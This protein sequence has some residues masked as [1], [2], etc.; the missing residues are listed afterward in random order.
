M[1]IDIEALRDIMQ[2]AGG[3]ALCLLPFTAVWALVN[4]SG[5]RPGARKAARTA[6][7][8][9]FAIVVITEGL[10]ALI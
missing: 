6:N 3:I 7:L 4:Q 8:V 1:M 9:V 5:K 2:A 10:G